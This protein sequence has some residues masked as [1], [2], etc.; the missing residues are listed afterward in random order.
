MDGPRLDVVLWTTDIP[1]LTR[2]LEVAGGLEV[3]ARHPGFASLLVN[4]SRI[5]LHH[6]ETFRGHPWHEALTREGVARGI[7][8]EV[9][10]R[11]ED[12]GRAYAS[13]LRLGALAI[14]AP[15]E[16]DGTVE[17]QVM[18]PD[19]FL[20]TLWREWPTDPAGK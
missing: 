1:A 17:C 18:G 9:R 6:D 5:V 2:F 15:C 12:V 11:V 10:I 13:A 3:E 20:L 14:E 7:G 19:G 16:V 8:A 4:G